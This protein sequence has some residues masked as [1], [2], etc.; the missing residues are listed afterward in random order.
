[1]LTKKQLERAQKQLEKARDHLLTRVKSARSSFDPADERDTDEADI[2]VNIQ[3]RAQELWAK[4]GLQHR[5]Y[6]VEHALDRMNQGKYGQCEVC[7]QDIDP[8]R[9]LILPET[10]TCVSC[11]A[12]T[13]RLYR[14]AAQSEEKAILFDM[15]EDAEDMDQRA[16]GQGLDLDDDA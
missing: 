6:E 8:D 14:A 13:E 15:D 5:L 4:D 3:T 11:R 1:M 7:G 9:L 10:T 2:I 12:R 16:L